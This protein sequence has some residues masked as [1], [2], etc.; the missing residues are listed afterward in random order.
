MLRGAFFNGCLANGAL[1]AI[2]YLAEVVDLVERFIVS[3]KVRPMNQ[4]TV[5]RTQCDVD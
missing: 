2:L 5:R 3:G 4:E 1:D